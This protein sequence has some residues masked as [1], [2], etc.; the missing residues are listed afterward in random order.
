M[1]LAFGENAVQKGFEE[2]IT[3]HLSKNKIKRLLGYDI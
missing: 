1:I 3:L 2:L